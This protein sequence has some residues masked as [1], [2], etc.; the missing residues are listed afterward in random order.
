MPT[1]GARPAEREE[2]C[3][4]EQLRVGVIGTGFGAQI[5]APAFAAVENCVVVEVVTPRDD[6]AVAALCKRPD[7]NL[8]SVHSPPFLHVDHVRRAVGAGH[9][10]LCDKPFGRNA[11]DSAAMLELARAAGVLHFLNF[12]RRFDVARE[13]LRALLLDGAIGEPNHFQYSRFIAMPE[14]R[15]YGWLCSRAL[16]GG[17]LAGQGSHLIDACRWL[18]GE[19][20]EATAVLRTPIIE[21]ADANG[22]L[23]H[24][25]ADDG[26]TAILRTE[27]G[28]TAV[29]DSMLEAPV[30]TGEHTA[31]FGSTGLLEITDAGGVVRRTSDGAVETY[32][33]D[34]QGTLPLLYSMQRWASLMCDAVR[35]GVVQPDWPTFED[36]LACSLVMDRMG[37]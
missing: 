23:R 9:A 26:F 8:I 27:T 16:G 3:V 11:E 24:C 14:P 13:R 6:A 36:G 4:T 22:Q 18:F 28:V 30:N 29:I 20:V 21:R 15:P 17:W 33:V 19:I 37:R 5:V 32:D 34:T 1:T 7:I 12:E 25:D 35:T 2:I 31:V 10:V